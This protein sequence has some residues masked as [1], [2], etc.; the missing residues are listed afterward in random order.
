[1]RFRRPNNGIVELSP[2]AAATLLAYR[3]TGRS[4]LEAGGVMLGRHILGTSD[5][6]IDRVSEPDPADRRSRFWFRRAKRPAQEVVDRAWRES[7]GVI[8]YL[9]EWH[10]HP[11][12]DPTPSCVDRRDWKRI[13]RRVKIENADL[14]FIIVGIKSIRVWEVNRRVLQLCLLEQVEGA[15]AQSVPARV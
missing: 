9:G 14:F 3:Q 4:S 12:D 1:M 8:N 5:V 10:S 13:A 7:N 6:V 15:A 2:G 11:E